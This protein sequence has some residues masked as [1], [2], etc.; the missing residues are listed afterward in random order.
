[1][2]KKLMVGALCMGLAVAS[3][4]GL[5]DAGK[6]QALKAGLQ[7]QLDAF[8]PIKNASGKCVALPVDHVKNSGTQAIAENCEGKA[9]QRWNLKDGLISNPG[10]LCLQPVAAEGQP[11][12]VQAIT[13]SEAEDKSA[14]MWQV[15][16]E[17]AKGA[18]LKLGDQCLSTENGD[19]NAR[20]VLQGC[21]ENNANQ[22]WLQ[23][24]KA[25]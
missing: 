24:A 8:Q 14:Q 10:K 20:L 21:D 7:Q 23:E 9:N 1:M 22:K 17:F 4:A 16:G 5:P 6:L 13:C 19:A 2:T 15:A 18:M 12:V 3:Q 25:E 11:T